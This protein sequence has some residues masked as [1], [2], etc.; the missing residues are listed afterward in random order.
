MS[1]DEI[2]PVLR[3]LQGGRSPVRGEIVAAL[4]QHPPF[5]VEARVYEEDRWLVLSS[6]L[7]PQAVEEHPI[8]LMTALWVAEPQSPGSVVVKL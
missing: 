2:R 1:G 6:P 8:R 4:E 5:L 3:V 7:E